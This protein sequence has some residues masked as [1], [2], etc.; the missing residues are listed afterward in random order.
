MSVL[1]VASVL[2]AGCGGG[3]TERSGPTLSSP[4]VSTLS[5]LPAP[6]S[7]PPT[8]EI[9]ADLRQS[10]RDAAAGRM[11]VWIGNDTAAPITLTKIEYRDP[12]LS[13]VVYG[14]RLRTNPSQS[15]RGHSLQLPEPDCSAP[16]TAKPKLT[17]EY[18][19]RTTRIPVDDEIGIV[20]RYVTARC[21]EVAVARVAQLS[22]SDQVA[23]DG[24]AGR[25]ELVVRPT[26]RPGGVLAIDEINGTPVLGAVGGSSWR[27]KVTV[28]SD[29]RPSRLA[30]DVIPARCDPH[31]FAESGGAT[32]FRIH[33]RLNG[34][35]GQIVLRMTSTGAH[36]A[37]D[38]ALAAC[39]FE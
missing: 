4:A 6:P 38:F 37:I 33:L 12:R 2:L 24:E 30:L 19:G 25:L 27:P 18:D 15:E 20:E 1:V 28:N 34:K 11:Q 3:T 8:G 35:P 36:N 31:A 17:L 39:G 16:V 14:D 21:L 9:L 23:R 13:E 7:Q 26:G 5:P 22:W 32:A 10:S 29:D